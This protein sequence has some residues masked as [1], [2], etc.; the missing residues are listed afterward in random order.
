MSSLRA[1][2][3]AVDG[4]SFP[5]HKW[6]FGFVKEAF[7]KTKVSIEEIDSLPESD[8][9]F[10]VIAGWEN[11]D[12]TAEVSKELQKIKRVVLF[13]TGDESG[14]FNYDGIDHP[15]I[16]IWVQ[17]PYPKH[18][19]YNKM[20]IGV[21]SD[22][23]KY[24]PK[25]QNK[26]YDAFYSGQ[27]NHPRREELVKA[28]PKIHNSLCNATPG[29]TQGYSLSEYYEK[30]HQ[31]KICPCPAGAMT[32]DSFRFYEAIEMLSLPIADSKSSVNQLMEFWELLFGNDLPFKQTQDWNE[33]EN[34]VPE[35]LN[36]YPKNLHRVV[37]WW[38]KYKRDFRNK[39]M[40]QVNE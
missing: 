17:S 4:K 37:A 39:I 33:L 8:R 16:E 10:V 5:T 30:M 34:I 27:V 23:V 9:A 3:L 12:L 28:L 20:P 31:S 2:A 6:D 15:N 40:E 21:T 7:E 1:Y 14:S 26:I 36:D 13:V 22:L 19:K 29:F 38:I 35:L 18:A 11:K 25:Y 32:I 24:V